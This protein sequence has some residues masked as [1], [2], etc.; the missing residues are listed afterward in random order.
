MKLRK[1]K[2][3][4]NMPDHTW[5]SGATNHH[6]YYNQE[7]NAPLTAHPAH[8]WQMTA[9]RTGSIDIVK[10]GTKI[11]V[12]DKDSVRHESRQIPSSPR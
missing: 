10:Y 12:I 5:N 4:P 6:E 9:K 7:I 1:E 11:S 8:L 3:L 2:A